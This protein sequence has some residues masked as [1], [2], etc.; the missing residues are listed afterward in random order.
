MKTSDPYATWVKDADG[1]PLRPRGE[2]DPNLVR[3]IA[4]ACFAVLALIFAGLSV[5]DFSTSQGFLA[6]FSGLS[7]HY[8]LWALIFAALACSFAFSSVMSLRAAY[9]VSQGKQL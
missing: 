8:V 7:D 2:P 1:R 6:Q 3:M 5:N 9:L 4:G